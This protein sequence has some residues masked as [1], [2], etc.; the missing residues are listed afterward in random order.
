M[1]NTTIGNVDREFQRL[2]TQAQLTWK[3]E[4]RTL[5]WLGLQEDM[6]VIELG[7]GPGF[8]TEQL[9]SL[10]PNGSVIA[11]EVDP[12]M[13]KHAKQYLQD[14]SEDRVKIIEASIM[15]TGL[16]DNS[17]DFAYARLIFQHLPDPVG[18]A[19]EVLRV[20]KPGGKI[21]I[22]DQDD[23]YSYVLDPPMPE[24]QLVFEKIDQ[25]QKNWG[26]NGRIGRQLLRILKE[27]GF[28]NVDL[29]AIISHSEMHRIE[30]FFKALDPE[31]V[32]QVFVNAGLLIENLVEDYKHA[33]EKFVTLPNSCF[34]FVMLMGYGE[35]P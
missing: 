29:E 25:I 9:L 7:S 13:V 10:L 28:H 24:F 26:G 18:A 30:D 31:V 16:P 33:I 27:A 34:L 20:L 15:D 1:V 35:K 2:R 17:F 23:D 4:A 6:S 5:S 21:I 22:S 11:V 12:V 19:K 8:T 14:V 32:S 3:K